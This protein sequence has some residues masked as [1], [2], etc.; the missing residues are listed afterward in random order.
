MSTNIK[1]LTWPIWIWPRVISYSISIEGQRFQKSPP[2]C[3]I[4]WHAE[5]D[6][7]SRTYLKNNP[8]EVKVRKSN[9]S[10]NPGPIRQF[11]IAA[12]RNPQL[13]LRRFDYRSPTH[14][15]SVLRHR[16]RAALGKSTLVLLRCRVSMYSSTPMGALFVRSDSHPYPQPF[17]HSGDPTVDLGLAQQ[18]S[19]CHEKLCNVEGK[20]DSVSLSPYF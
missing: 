18:V 19:T 20:S 15:G 13:R 3:T 10:K 9:L 5:L 2:T 8:P 17:S 11:L 4:I 14:V 1:N 12:Q 7:F 16:T 6:T